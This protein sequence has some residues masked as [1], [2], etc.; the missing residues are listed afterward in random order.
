MFVFETTLQ[1]KPIVEALK[2]ICKFFHRVVLQ[3]SQRFNIIAIFLRKVP[4]EPGQMAEKIIDV[5]KILKSS[6]ET[7]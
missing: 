5:L 1:T 4:L 2:N 7:K 6:M 3:F